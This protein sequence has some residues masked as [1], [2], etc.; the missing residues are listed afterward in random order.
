MKNLYILQK[1]PDNWKNNKLN[2]NMT[3][4]FPK[5]AECLYVKV[6]ILEK[7]E[8]VSTTLINT[9]TESKEE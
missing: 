5:S 1:E 6:I 3:F 7:S 8:P 9:Q 2:L 4:I